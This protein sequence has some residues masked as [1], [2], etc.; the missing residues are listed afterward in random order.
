MSSKA[1][2]GAQ[3]ERQATVPLRDNLGPL[4]YKLTG[5]AVAVRHPADLCH[6]RTAD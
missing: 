4:H 3:G 5:D 1:A 2:S 6:E